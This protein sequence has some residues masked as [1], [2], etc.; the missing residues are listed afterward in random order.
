[1]KKQDS[2]DVVMRTAARWAI[3]N[4]E[5]LQFGS[6][7]DARRKRGRVVVTASKG[8]MRWTFEIS[9]FRTADLDEV[10]LIETVVADRL[11]HIRQLSDALGPV[12]GWDGAWDRD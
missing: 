8:V 12:V 6:M 1:M 3:D 11:D 4:A 2:T 5:W 7:I 9:R 10:E